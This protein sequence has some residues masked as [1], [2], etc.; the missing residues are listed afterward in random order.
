MLSSV[1][2]KGSAATEDSIAGQGAGRGMDPSKGSGQ[3]PSR[4]EGYVPVKGFVLGKDLGRELG[5]RSFPSEGSVALEGCSVPNKDS[6]RGSGDGEESSHFQ[7]DGS[8]PGKGPVALD[9]SVPDQRKGH[10]TISGP[11]GTGM[12]SCVPVYQE[13]P[14]MT[15]FRFRRLLAL[16]ACTR[17]T[18]AFQAYAFNIFSSL[19]CSC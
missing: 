7:I 11:R 15:R 9:G 10:G 4:S 13:F 2:T 3:G 12:V 18:S 5:R 19:L 8:V 17:F 14:I 6:S 1:S 16:L